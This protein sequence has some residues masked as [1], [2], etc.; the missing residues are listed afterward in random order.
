M[1]IYLSALIFFLFACKN[2]ECEGFTT[3]EDLDK[4]DLIKCKVDSMYI[5]MKHFSLAWNNERKKIGIPL[6]SK[7]LTGMTYTVNN[8]VR[9]QDME[10]M[11]DENYDKPFLRHKDLE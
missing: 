5:Y 11:L 2:K 7:H 9:W 6:L 1:K 4:A 3:A 10:K 8:Q